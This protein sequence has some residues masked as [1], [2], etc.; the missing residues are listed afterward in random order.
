MMVYN[1]GMR[2]L[3]YSIGKNVRD[4]YITKLRK[5]KSRMSAFKSV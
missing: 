3:I 2:M 5:I 4:G 1:V